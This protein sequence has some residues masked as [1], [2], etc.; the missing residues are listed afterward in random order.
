[1]TT[2]FMDADELDMLCCGILEAGV[3][4]PEEEDM[5]KRHTALNGRRR[6]V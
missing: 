1:M 3:M 2:V 4:S 6:A 5:I